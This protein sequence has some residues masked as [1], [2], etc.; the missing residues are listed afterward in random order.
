MKRVL[1]ARSRSNPK[2]MELNRNQL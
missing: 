1:Q 2:A